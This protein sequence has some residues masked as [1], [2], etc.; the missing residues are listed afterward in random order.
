MTI[1]KERFGTMSS[2]LG[3][4]RHHQGARS[5]HSDEYP[6]EIL[7]IALSFDLQLDAQVP[8]RGLGFLHILGIPAHTEVRSG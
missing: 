5:L 4:I 2:K 8:C 7:R 1:T 6:V 3:V